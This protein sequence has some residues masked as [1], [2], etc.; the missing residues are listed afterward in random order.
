M[1]ATA[2][3]SVGGSIPS[4]SRHIVQRLA[5]RCKSLLFLDYRSRSVVCYGL[6]QLPNASGRLC[7]L[8]RREMGMPQD[9]LIRLSST[10]LHQRLQ[11]GSAHHRPACPGVPQ[12]VKI[13]ILNI[14]SC[15]GTFPGSAIDS[16]RFPFQVKHHFVCCPC[17]ALMAGLHP[18]LSVSNVRLCIHRQIPTRVMRPP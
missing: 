15:Q 18:W 3:Q 6:Q 14:R 1:A 17:T 7:Q 8:L 12:A 10:S 13:E 5:S 2:N 4:T 11:A 16:I 9:H